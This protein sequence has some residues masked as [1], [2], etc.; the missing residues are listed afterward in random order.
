MSEKPHVAP[1]H[2]TTAFYARVTKEESVKK[3]LSLP[4]Q[5][6]RFGEL[7]ARY[8]WTSRH[9][10][11]PKHVSGE[12]GPVERPALAQLL[13]DIHSGTA[14][15][16]VVRH[17]DR[18]GRGPVLESLLRE[19]HLQGIELWTFDGQVDYRSAG[20]RFQVRVQAAAGAFEVER[21]GER[22]REARRNRARDG[23]HVGPAPYGY[24][25]QARLCRQLVALYGEDTAGREKARIEAQE[26]IPVRP[27]LVIDP[28]EAEVVRVIFAMYVGEGIGSRLIANRLNEMGRQRRGH[29][30]H[31]QTVQKVLHDPKVAGLTHY[32]EAAYEAKRPS[33]AR[34]D[35]QELY[36]AKHEAI[37]DR[38]TWDE[39]QS[40]LARRSRRR[41]ASRAKC[42]TYPLTGAI[43]CR[44]GHRMKGKSSGGDGNP[45]YYTCSLRGTV[46]NDPARGGCD[47]PPIPADRA[48]AMAREALAD[49]LSSPENILAVM[50]EANRRIA[51]EAPARKAELGEIE[52]DIQAHRG[53]QE[54]LLR[55]LEGTDDR[56]K[57]QVILDRL[58][59]IKD[60]V[61]ELEVRRDELRV[62]VIPI[63][64]RRISKDR[65][66]AF[67][68]GLRE[69][70]TDDPQRFADLVDALR[71]HH[72]LRV[73]VLDAYRV[74]LEL[75]LDAA[76]LAGEGDRR[77]VRLVADVTPRIPVVIEEG[78]ARPL[79]PEE[80]AEAE[81]AKGTHICACGCGGL[82]GVLPKHHAPGVGIPRFIQGHHRMKMTEFVET[83][84]ADGYLTVGQA[85]AELGI[86]ETTLRR[87]E[88]KGW[89]TPERRPWGDRQP[90]RVYRRDDLPGLRAKMMEACFRFK[91]D[92]DVMTTRQVADELGV[93]ENTLRRMERKGAVAA[94]ERDTGNRRKWKR[95]DLPKLKRA[96]VRYRRPRVRQ[97]GG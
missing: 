42:R 59:E 83:L 58:M 40:I 51:A 37:I 20:G 63:Q 18:L 96:L 24:T 41:S 48:E 53:R 87:A 54:R 7:A 14:R 17:L 84:N 57:A 73:V 2:F 6:R 11:E 29:R 88:E 74:R 25:S 15:R 61:R 69:R 39:A 64:T 52:A 36:T 47:A 21:G 78:V 85:A 67:L 93:S 26:R 28:A 72:G 81:N 4:N 8:G 71:R 12:V 94:P 60:R 79:T 91:D 16:V 70:L 97:S 62:A 5:R 56:G 44:A 45:A 66:A 46:G 65:V 68:A 33:S 30:W 32:D 76:Q 38:E 34:I 1:E 43:E 9:Y 77:P 13:A 23:Y 49:L 55:L 27:G 10:E 35:R 86:G 31:P 19:F 92:E 95:S 90:M 75:H 80:W 89:V 82:I 3:G 50:D 22:V